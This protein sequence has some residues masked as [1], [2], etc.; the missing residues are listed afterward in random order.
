MGGHYESV[1]VDGCRQVVSAAG[2]LRTECPVMAVYVDTA[3]NRYRR[4]M[5]MSH[6]LADS[7]S[8]LHAMADS[9]GLKREWF[10]AHPEHPHYDL[11]QAKRKLAL[12]YGARELGRRELV[13]LM[14]R[15][16]AVRAA[17]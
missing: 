6:M 4:G 8:E 12:Q 1:A 2:R 13:A 3:R 5:V 15:L 9:I 17:A 16:R 10:Q 11:C 14:R 7:L